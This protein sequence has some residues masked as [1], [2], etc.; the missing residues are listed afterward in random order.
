MV[1]GKRVRV[2]PDTK[3]RLRQRKHGGQTF[4]QVIAELLDATEG[5]DA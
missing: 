4:S 2:K 5:D 1:K 3:E